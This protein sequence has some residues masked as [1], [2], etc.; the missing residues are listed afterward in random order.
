MWR[1][2]LSTNNYYSKVASYMWLQSINAT[3]LV[4]L[5]K[6]C[7]TCFYSSKSMKSEKFPFQLILTTLKITLVVYTL[8]QNSCKTV[9]PHTEKYLWRSP[10]ILQFKLQ[11]IQMKTKNKDCIKWCVFNRRSFPTFWKLGTRSEIL[12]EENSV[13]IW[14]QKLHDTKLGDM[15]LS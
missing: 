6:I 5:D 11:N 12:K 13:T 2:L 14:R 10:F 8:W 1:F 4:K 3:T 7:Q 15:R 9:L